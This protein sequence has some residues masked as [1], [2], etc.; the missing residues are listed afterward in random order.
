LDLGSESNG[1]HG[2]LKRFFLLFVLCLSLCVGVLYAFVTLCD[3]VTCCDYIIGLGL[4]CLK[5]ERWGLDHGLKRLSFIFYRAG[6]F[7]R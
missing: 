7:P 1:S 5:R 3:T 6:I 4:T 2:I